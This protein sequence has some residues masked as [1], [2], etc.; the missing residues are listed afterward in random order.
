MEL[1]L[2][3]TNPSPSSYWYTQGHNMHA[4]CTLSNSNACNEHSLQGVICQEC[5]VIYRYSSLSHNVPINLPE[6]AGN[7]P[8]PAPLHWWRGLQA[9][10]PSSLG[11]FF[12]YCENLGSRF[13][14]LLIYFM[15]H[16]S[17]YRPFS[18][19][20]YFYIK[21]QLTSIAIPMIKLRRSH[22]CLIIIMGICIPG[23]ITFNVLAKPKCLPVILCWLLYVTYFFYSYCGLSH[24]V[25]INLPE[26]AGNGPV[27]SPLQRIAGTFLSPFHH[28]LWKCVIKIS[29]T[30]VFYDSSQWCQM[31]YHNNWYAF[32][33]W[34]ISC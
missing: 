15:I 29:A 10:W 25:P 1:P 32:S 13:Q 26:C 30:D 34:Q 22:N 14:L 31:F 11:P 8:V 4:S 2:S 6:C 3:C 33:F 27:L 23:I 9:P 21:H 12:T 24:N 19:S 18:S 5:L 7:G 20:W 16:L 17:G 28:L